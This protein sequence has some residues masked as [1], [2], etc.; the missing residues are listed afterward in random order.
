MMTP[1]FLTAS[2]NGISGDIAGWQPLSLS[3]SGW[4]IF[5]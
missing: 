5:F 3:F 4:Q 2:S 1:T